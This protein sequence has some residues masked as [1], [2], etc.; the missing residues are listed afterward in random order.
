MTTDQLVFRE[1]ISFEGFSIHKVFHRPGGHSQTER[2]LNFL[3]Y[4]SHPC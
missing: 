2:N 1:K 4:L 3:Q